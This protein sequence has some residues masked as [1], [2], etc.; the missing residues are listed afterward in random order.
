MA[1]TKPKLYNTTDFLVHI[2][3]QHTCI[4]GRDDQSQNGNVEECRITIGSVWE[5]PA[6]HRKGSPSQ[7]NHIKKSI[8]VYTRVWVDNFWLNFDVQVVG[9]VYTQVMPHSQSQHDSYQSATLTVC[10]CHT[11]CGPLVGHQGYV[12]AWGRA[13]HSE[14]P[15]TDLCC[16]CIASHCNLHSHIVKA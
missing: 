10:V 7:R 6:S 2:N 13:R 5:I 14:W 3:Q 9:S 11:Q 15:H 16:C 12:D 8:P 4:L 1:I